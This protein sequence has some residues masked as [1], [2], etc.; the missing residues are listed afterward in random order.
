[1]TVRAA[2]R[3]CALL[4]IGVLLTAALI[5]WRMDELRWRVQVLSLVARGEIPDLGLIEAARMLRP[6]SKYYLR[7]LL[8]TRNPYASISNPDSSPQ[9]IEAG[10]ALFRSNCSAC[11]G[12]DAR[13]REIAPSLLGRTFAHGDSDWA[14]YRTIRAGV[15]G[16]IMPPHTWEPARIWQVV[17]YLRSLGAA[18]AAMR[19]EA[20]MPQVTVADLPYE[21]LARIAEPAD[22]W[23]TYSGSYFG[24]RHSKL[25]QINRDNVARLAPRWIYQFPMDAE[26][27][28]VSPIVRGGVLFAVHLG[29][30]VALDAH[31][32]R[33]MWQYTRSAGAD[34][35]LCC[36][37]ATRGLAMLGD[38]IFFGT[39]DAHLIALSA[40][41]GQL[42]WDRPLVTDY[43]EG[44]SITSAPLAY[45]DMVVTGISGGDYPT[46]GF[47]AAFD[48]ATGKER[49]RFWTIPGPGEPGH[50]TWSGDSWRHGG[51]ATWM[52]GSYDPTLDLLYWGVGNPAPDFD[53]SIRKGDNLYTNSV[54]ALQGSTGQKVWHFQFT[55][56]DDHDWDSN[57]IPV[58]VDRPQAAAH[59]L[60][61]ANRNGFFYVLNRQTGAFILGTPFVQQTWAAG[62]DKNGRPIRRATA[63]PTPKGTLVYPGVGGGTHWWPP[64][65]DPDLDLMIVSALERP[66]VFF[67]SPGEA[68]R[69]GEFYLGGATS[70][71][72]GQMHHW[73]VKALDPETGKVAWEHSGPATTADIHSAGLLSTRGGVVFASNDQLFYA[74]DARD[75]RLL[76]TFPT[77]ARIAAAPIT[78]A[79]EGV[80]YVL[81]AAGRSIIAFAL[82]PG[83]S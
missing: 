20:A 58:V 8:D 68:P 19:A 13:G 49:W 31:D 12:V 1:M 69:S 62:L 7:G 42:V 61:W 22:D 5:V 65:Y 28:E 2:L 83:G 29:H 33:L 38:K 40:R 59:E 74:L 82:V 57:Q 60:L 66:G 48:A 37:S 3:V 67:S 70:G 56:G 80:Q 14:I 53:A 75:G 27:L 79:V 45:H 52:T 18:P 76:W 35:K 51:G 47:L 73:T 17:A 81:I 25:T 71:V 77:G 54:V 36:A 15:P 30:V 32:G 24:A 11:H 43:R 4:V 16:T 41:A 23:L 34:T 72:P 10:A 6:G 64:T 44:Y 63:A 55:P 9:D 39:A 26:F 50:E 78:Y 21:E 46:R